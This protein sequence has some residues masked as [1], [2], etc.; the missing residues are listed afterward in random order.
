[1]NLSWQIVRLNLKETFSIAY[2]N[3]SH[4]E[5]L[6]I[7][8]SKN[9]CTG[10]GECTAI[11][12]YQINLNDFTDKLAKVKATIE[13]QKI[14]HPTEFYTFLLTL[15]LPSFL[16]SAID[17]AYW[18]LFGKLEKQSFLEWNKIDLNYLPQSSITIS[19]APIEEQIKKI[20]QSNWSKFK[21]KCNHFN[22]LEIQ[23]LLQLDNPIAI[24]SN[25]SFTKENCNWLQNQEAISKFM[26]KFNDFGQYF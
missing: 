6:I 4:R 8:L 20:K 15:E 16:R 26:L 7:S 5:A 23:S 19:V 12:Y 1:M 22:E 17:C 13:N 3:Y 10:Y 24:D 11:D 2:G 9:D 14:L 18:D 25:G 21:V